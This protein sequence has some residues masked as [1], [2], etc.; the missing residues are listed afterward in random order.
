MPYITKADREKFNDILRA[1]NNLPELTNKG[2]LEYLLF[3]LM[4]KYM[5]TREFRYSTLHDCT[6]AA[7]H[8][9]DEFRRR[10]LD[11]RETE[12][13]EKNGDIEI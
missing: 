7:Q 3:Y 1:I 11:V 5:T 4:K 12:A 8:V 10:Y 13:R 9:C 2:E 6:Y